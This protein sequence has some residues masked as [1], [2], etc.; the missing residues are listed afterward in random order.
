[1]K[2][3]L[4]RYSNEVNNKIEIIKNKYGVNANQ[5]IIMAIE[6]FEAMISG[7]NDIVAHKMIEAVTT[8]MEVKINQ[9]SK[10]IKK[11]INELAIQTNINTQ[12]MYGVVDGIS[13]EEKK[14]MKLKAI[15]DVYGLSTYSKKKVY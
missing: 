14:N 6:E 8:V 7:E 15:D 4:I 5:A 12:V 1:M 11:P 3:K 2:K 13:E 9:M 10:E